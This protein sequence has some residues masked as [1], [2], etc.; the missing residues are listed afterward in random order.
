[1]QSYT[2]FDFIDACQ[3]PGCP[4]CRLEHKY[5]RGYLDTLFHE[6]VNDIELR[7]TLRLSKGFCPEHGWLPTSTWQVTWDLRSYTRMCSTTPLSN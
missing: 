4:V 7:K 5:I 6:N 1:M 2:A 3:E